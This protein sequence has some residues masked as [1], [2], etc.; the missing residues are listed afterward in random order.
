M[1][2]NFRNADAYNPERFNPANPDAQ[3]ESNSLIGFGG[4]VHR[5]AGV[6]FARMEMKVLLAILL[7]NFDMELIDEV[8]PVAGASTYW[9]AQPCRVRYRRRKLDGAAPVA[10]AAT[11]AKAAG[12]PAHG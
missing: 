4:G 1:E 10:T 11:L 7:Q 5:C 2:E 3:I 9:P 8:R 6:N 12:C